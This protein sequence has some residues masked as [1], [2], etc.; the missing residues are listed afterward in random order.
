MPL[1]PLPGRTAVGGAVLLIVWGLAYGGGRVPPGDRTRR[2]GRRDSRAGE[3]GLRTPPS[4]AREPRALRPPAGPAG[5]RNERLTAP[6]RTR[7]RRRRR[8][9]SRSPGRRR[10]PSCR[11]S[12]RRRR[13]RRRSRGSARARRGRRRRRR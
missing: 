5:G 6:V 7:T 12:P 2:A 13:T 1:F 11:S 9:R 4:A 10:R 3:P 8:A